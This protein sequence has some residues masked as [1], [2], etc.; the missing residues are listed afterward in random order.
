[1]SAAPAFAVLPSMAMVLID[2]GIAPDR[3]LRRAGLPAGEATMPARARRLGL[4][5]R[6][7]QRRFGEEGTAFQSLV[8]ETRETLALHCLR[9]S[10]LPAAEISLLLGYQDQTSFYRAFRAWTG[11]TPDSTRA[12]AGAAVGA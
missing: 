6:T 11:T 12:A 8:T 1:M 7:L 4:S 5:T 2:A 10:Q 3:V 9:R